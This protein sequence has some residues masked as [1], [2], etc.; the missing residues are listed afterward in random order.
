MHAHNDYLGISVGNIWTTKSN[1]AAIDWIGYNIPL[2]TDKQEHVSGFG[3]SG[4]DMAQRYWDSFNNDPNFTYLHL[5]L[6]VLF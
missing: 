6:G 3:L 4:Q 5:K 2:S 1:Y